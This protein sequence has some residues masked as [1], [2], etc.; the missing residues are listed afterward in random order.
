MGD[1][2]SRVVE[3]VRPHFYLNPSQIA[4]LHLG[5]STERNPRILRL[6]LLRAQQPPLHWLPSV[7]RVVELPLPLPPIHRRLATISLCLDCHH[8]Y[9]TH[10]D[11]LSLAHIARVPSLMSLL[12]IWH[13]LSLAPVAR[14]PSLIS[15]CAFGITLRSYPIAD[16]LLL[17]CYRLPFRPVAFLAS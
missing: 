10:Q 6:Q 2:N 3:P 14:L 13:H 15:Y 12:R 1:R 7:R 17:V 5:M 11:H 8:S 4:S 9:I 16:L